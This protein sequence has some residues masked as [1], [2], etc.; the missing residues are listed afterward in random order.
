MDI[1]TL[2]FEKVDIQFL[3]SKFELKINR[4][5]GESPGPHDQ[6]LMVHHYHRQ[7]EVERKIK[8]RY[9]SESA[10]VSQNMQVVPSVPARCCHS[11]TTVK[12]MTRNWDQPWQ[13]DQTTPSQ[14]EI[15]TYYSPIVGPWYD[16]KAIVNSLCV[17]MRCGHG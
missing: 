13:G 14:A 11:G 6:F 4:H 7:Q 3:I 17:Q 9:S 8:L 2:F 12:T 16:T 1:E 10:V 15:S 5:Y